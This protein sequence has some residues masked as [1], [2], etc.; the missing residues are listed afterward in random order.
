MSSVPRTVNPVVAQSAFDARLSALGKAVSSGNRPCSRASST[1]S[2]TAA[3]ACPRPAPWAPRTSRSRGRRCHATSSTTSRP[4]R[5]RR[6]RRR[7]GTCGPRR[8]P[9]TAGTSGGGRGPVP[10]SRPAEVGRHAGRV[11][12]AEQREVV[13]R[14]P[15]EAHLCHTPSIRA[16]GGASPG[17]C[18]RP[19][20]H[21]AGCSTAGRDRGRHATARPRATTPARRGCA[22]CGCRGTAA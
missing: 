18:G 22:G 1:T 16:T 21:P 19:A 17:R 7:C 14:P 15:V 12:G 3:A 5:P 8:S 11:A 6:R 9:S 2:R 20:H 4:P 13:V 10:R